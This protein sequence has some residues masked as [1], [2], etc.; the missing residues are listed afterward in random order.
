MEV[1]GL[2]QTLIGMLREKIIIGELA[3]GQDINETELS[4]DLN[5]SRSPLRE[6]LKALESERLIIN[7]PRKGSYVSSV[8]LQDLTEIYQMREM[9]ECYAIDLFE[10]K[11]IGAHDGLKSCVE[12]TRDEAV[13]SEDASKKEKL[14]YI[15]SLAEFHLEL[16]RAAGN[17]RLIKFYHAIY[18]NINRYVFLHAFV[19]GVSEHR[20]NE[21]FKIIQCIQKSQFKEAKETIKAHIQQSY[22]DL[23]IRING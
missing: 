5:I 23:R 7:I 6:A 2:V 21:H 14:S 15:E 17:G 3:P 18:S 8:S 11:G 22:E 19:N 1:L 12:K 9:I 4:K 16:V 10:E 13:P 20:V